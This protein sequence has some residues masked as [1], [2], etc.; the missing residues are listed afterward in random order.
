MNGSRAAIH[1]SCTLSATTLFAIAWL[2]RRDE[3]APADGT[4]YGA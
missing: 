3:P 2:L 1:L 4:S